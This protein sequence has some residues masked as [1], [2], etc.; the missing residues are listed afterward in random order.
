MIRSQVCGGGG[1][2]TGFLSRT[3]PLPMIPAASTIYAECPTPT[4]ICLPD[5]GNDFVFQARLDDGDPATLLVGDRRAR[6]GV[7]IGLGTDRVSCPGNPSRDAAP[8]E[9]PWQ[10]R[11]QSWHRSYLAGCPSPELPGW[12]RTCG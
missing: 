7:Q 9:G 12:G 10:A 8:D 4:S 1:M 6:A 5:S 3:G 2:M 11:L